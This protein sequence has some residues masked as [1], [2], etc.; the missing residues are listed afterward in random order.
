MGGD[1]G[2][3]KAIG[4]SRLQAGQSSATQALGTVQGSMGGAV[5]SQLSHPHREA[6]AAVEGQQG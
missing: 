4:V 3:A 1:S 2:V 5:L 6:E